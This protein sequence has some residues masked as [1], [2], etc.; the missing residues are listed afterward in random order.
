MHAFCGTF[1]GMPATMRATAAIMSLHRR[2]HTRHYDRCVGIIFA[3]AATKSVITAT[4]CTPAVTTCG[5]AVI[6][7]V[8]AAT[9]PATH[10]GEET[11]SVAQ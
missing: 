6:F 1:R 9:M 11:R 10:T 2:D 7:R 5:M 8:I 4:T 3:I